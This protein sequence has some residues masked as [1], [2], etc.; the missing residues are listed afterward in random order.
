MA[1][2]PRDLDRIHSRPRRPSQ[3][4]LSSEEDDPPRGRVSPGK[5]PGLEHVIKPTEIW[6]TVDGICLVLVGRLI[7]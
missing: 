4:G 2:H 1:S 3:T 6:H 7:G 5:K